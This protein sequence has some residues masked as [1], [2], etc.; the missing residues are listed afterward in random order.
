MSNAI[1]EDQTEQEVNQENGVGDA[2]IVGTEVGEDPITSEELIEAS[3]DT[4][5]EVEVPPEQRD[6]I[7]ALQKPI[8][9]MSLKEKLEAVHRIRELRKVRLGATKKKSDLDLLL[10]QL[11]P[12][13]A[14]AVLKK[15]EEGLGAGTVKKEN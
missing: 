8:N 5:E 11:S 7:W 12:D 14:A 1:N 2:G 10:A 13:K 9:Q 3:A 6:L 4:L 15:L